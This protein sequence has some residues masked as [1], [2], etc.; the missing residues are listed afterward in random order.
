MEIE[1]SR[2]ASRLPV[3][4]GKRCREHGFQTITRRRYERNSE[5]VRQVITFRIDKTE[6]IDV[7][8][9]IDLFPG[10]TDIPVK[11]FLHG[12]LLWLAWPSQ[13][14]RYIRYCDFDLYTVL[15]DPDGWNS[16]FDRIWDDCFDVFLKDFGSL[17]DA[18]QNLPKWL[19]EPGFLCVKGLQQYLILR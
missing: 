7:T 19:Q 16:W 2:L 6:T 4:F 5:D 12:H 13:A 8:A 14:T 17:N 18:T 1:Q 10:R 15:L 3:F 9:W 11:S